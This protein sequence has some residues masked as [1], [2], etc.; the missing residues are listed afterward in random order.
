MRA[1][2]LLSFVLVVLLTITIVILVARQSATREVRT[3]MLR[4]AMTDIDIL[5]GDL[6]AYYQQNN[7]WEGVE[8]LLLPHGYQRGQ[9]QG[10]MMGQRI[11]ITDSNGVILVDT[12]ESRTGEQINKAGLSSGIKM[13]DGLKT[14]GYLVVEGGMGLNQ[15]AGQQLIERL[16]RA[17]LVAAVIAGSITLILALF[18]AYR[19]IRPVK[20][21]TEAAEKL[22]E[23]DL[24]QRVPIHGHD[25]LSSLGQSF[26]KM[27][28]SLQAS[29]KA[30]RAMTA[31]IAHELR[32]PLAVQR[33]S[34]EAMQDGIYPMT[35]ENLTPVIEQNIF[36]TRL[37]E[38]LRT[39]AL[40]DANQLDFDLT[41]FDLPGLC[42]KIINLYQTEADRRKIS[43]RLITDPVQNKPGLYVYADPMRVEQILSNLLS[44]ALRYTP[45]AGEILLEIQKTRENLVS[46]V[47]HDSGPGIPPETLPY[48]FDR[49]Y[50]VDKSRSREDGG[51]GLG[52]TIARQLAEAQGGALKASNHPDGGAI[53]TLTLPAAKPGGA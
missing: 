8:T 12:R 31:D 17:A 42:R 3:F 4:G 1:R 5:V 52:L 9:G 45:E 33:A 40:V 51:S 50:R 49:F 14:I 6:V 25:E 47:I 23:G 29:E 27:A 28:D 15:A 39:L 13:K 53:F 10:N 2:I 21:L 43:I 19:L 24:S 48:V 37:V 26:N 44:N 22:G 11:I 41:L 16:N 35:S 20:E 46:T 34:L 38:D 36:L 7:S 18:L 32:N 30:R